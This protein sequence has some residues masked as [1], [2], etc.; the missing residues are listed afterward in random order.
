MPEWC[1][2]AIWVVNVTSGSCFSRVIRYVSVRYG[3]VLS[4]KDVAGADTWQQVLEVAVTF[5]LMSEIGAVESSVF[6]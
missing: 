1:L 2:W 5:I 6:G 3:S 4:L